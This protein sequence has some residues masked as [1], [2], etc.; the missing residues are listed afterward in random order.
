V[1]IVV[2]VAKIEDNSLTPRDAND[3]NRYIHKYCNARKEGCKKKKKKRENEVKCKNF[4]LTILKEGLRPHLLLA[5]VQ[6][7]FSLV[8]AKLTPLSIH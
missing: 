3:G 6:F 7:Y 2:D 4:W 5:Y 8:L 1:S